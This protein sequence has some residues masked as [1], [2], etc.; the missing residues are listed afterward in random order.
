MNQIIVRP[1]PV[2]H[3]AYVQAMWLRF[4]LTPSKPTPE[5]DG[6]FNLGEIGQDVEK[7]WSRPTPYSPTEKAK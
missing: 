2:D 5:P 4:L 3:E 7:G 6:F 1:K